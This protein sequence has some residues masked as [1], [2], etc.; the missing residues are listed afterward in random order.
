MT[1]PSPFFRQHHG[2]E[3]PT[4]DLGAWRPYWRVR[5]RLD[6]L[7][8]DGAITPQEWSAAVRLRRIFEASYAAMLPIHRLDGKPHGGSSGPALA[9]RADALA[10]LEAVRAG[11]GSFALGL[12]EACL[13][14]DAS[15]RY[16]GSRLGVDPKTARAW[17]IAAIH[18]LATLNRNIR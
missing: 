13:A 16:L 7:L 3:P 17:T 5:T 2:L 8:L 14:D 9:R 1:S 10:R 18:A 11:L 12:L 6:R 15:W 4:L